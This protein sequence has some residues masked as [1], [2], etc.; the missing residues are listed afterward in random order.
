V[1]QGTSLLATAS[2]V[3]PDG[4]V[5]QGTFEPAWGEYFYP[6]GPECSPSCRNA[7]PQALAV[8]LPEAVSD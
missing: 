8:E 6:N 5:S 3:G 4:L 1:D 7:P 2:V